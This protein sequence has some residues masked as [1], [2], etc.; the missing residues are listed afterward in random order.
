VRSTENIVIV[1]H[2]FISKACGKEEIKKVI[3]KVRIA[4][5]KEEEALNLARQSN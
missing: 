1:Q 5:Q 4:K 3:K 2:P